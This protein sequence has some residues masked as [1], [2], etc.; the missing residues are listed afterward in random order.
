LGSAD[1]GVFGYAPAPDYAGYF[2]G[3]AK[4]TGNLEVGNIARIQ[5][6][7]WPS[8]GKSMELAYSSSL[9][10]GYIQ[11]YDRGT[12]TWGDLYL[13]G[14]KV[15]IGTADPARALHISDVMRLEPR[16]SYPSSP[17]D[18][19]LCIVGASGSRHIYCYLNGSWRQLD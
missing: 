3:V 11:V 4:T 10:R 17:S 18:G 19:D 8:T 1:Y 6:T 7:T 5:G 9:H 15:G 12:S 13:G 14:G 2:D 16:S